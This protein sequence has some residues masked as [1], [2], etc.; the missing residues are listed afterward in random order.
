M[1]N[2]FAVQYWSQTPYKFGPHIIKFSVKP[3]SGATNERPDVMPQDYLRD[4]TVKTIGKRDVEF[5]FLIQIQ[6]NP[7]TQPFEDPTVTWEPSETQENPHW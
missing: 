1:N 4:T 2:V 7:E 3:I 5:E 6:N